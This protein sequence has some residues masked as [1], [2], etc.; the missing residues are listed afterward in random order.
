MGQPLAYQV[1]IQASF[2]D[3]VELVID[4]LK[5]EGFGVITQIDVKN[6][7]KEKLGEEFRP[8]KI[9]GA[10]NPPLAHRA[11]VADPAVG[12]MLPCNVTVEEV[13]GEILVSL[14]NPERMLMLGALEDNPAM[15]EVAREA[16][17]RIR[18][19]ATHLGEL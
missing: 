9:L 6:T 17:D 16:N 12:V 8:Y 18:Q 13:D 1:R 7:L 11:L 3:A 10:C 19:V 5:K 2:D 14:A 4:A 15:Q